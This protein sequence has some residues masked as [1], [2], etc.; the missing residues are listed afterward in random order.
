MLSG[1]PPQIPDHEALW[2]RG[3]VA[4]VKED[5]NLVARLLGWGLAI[6]RGVRAHP[7][8]LER[9]AVSNKRGPSPRY[10]HLAGTFEQ[11]A[12]PVEKNSYFAKG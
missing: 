9:F 4:S 10:N 2:C 11:P 7:F 1:R 8:G 6:R 12:H 3:R 5:R